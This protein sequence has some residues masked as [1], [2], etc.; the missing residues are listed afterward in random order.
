MTVTVPQIARL[1][2]MIAE[3]STNLYSD[4]KLT[5]II[6]T[7][8]TVDENGES[9]RVPSTLVPGT[10][11]VNPD[12]TETYDLHSAAAACWEEKAG[13]AADKFDFTADG[14]T[15][16]RSQIYQNAMRQA[17]WHMSRRN[18]GTIILV[19]PETRERTYEINSA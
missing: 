12:W 11:M 3:P 17:R 14:G 6:E 13:T 9:P 7:Y 8:P 1:R 5:D 2:R 15:Y 18:P 4:A 16:V 19:T 10:M